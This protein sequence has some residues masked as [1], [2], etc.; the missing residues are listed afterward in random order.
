MMRALQLSP[1]GASWAVSWGQ[2]DA[3]VSPE[4]VAV[5][6][7]A[8]PEVAVASWVVMCL[9]GPSEASWGY[10]VVASL[11]AAATEAAAA[12]PWVARSL[13]RLSSLLPGGGLPSWEGLLEASSPSSD[14][15]VEGSLVVHR[16]SSRGLEAF[17]YATAVIHL[18]IP[19]GISNH[20]GGHLVI[21]DR[22]RFMSSSRRQHNPPTG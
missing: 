19:L 10:Q 16:P 18:S 15:F 21:D 14:G 22:F 17:C 2:L 13:P 4:V 20:Q 7:V 12:T 5:P 6:E 8:V 11:S 1:S 9:L 3:L